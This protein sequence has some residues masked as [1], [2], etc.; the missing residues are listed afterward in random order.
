MHTTRLILLS[1]FLGG[2]LLGCG[3]APATPSPQPLPS[4]TAVPTAQPTAYPE[5]S[6]FTPPAATYTPVTQAYPGPQNTP[7]P[8]PVRTPINPHVTPAP[9]K[10]NAT[11]IILN[12]QPNLGTY[13]LAGYPLYLASLMKNAE[14]AWTGVARVDEN[15]APAAITDDEGRFLFVNVPP[16]MYAL[17][18]KHPLRLIAVLDLSTQENP[19]IE[20]KPGEITDVGTLT[21][22]IGG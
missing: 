22:A 18:I 21:V 9:G 12:S 20:I 11:G 17:V 2:M 3:K 13:P 1:L 10:G 19:V 8:T 4:A 7:E 16:G 5:P 6:A 15:S 14:G